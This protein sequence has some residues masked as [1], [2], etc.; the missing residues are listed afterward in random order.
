MAL[1]PGTMRYRIAF[2]ATVITGIAYLGLRCWAVWGRWL[3]FAFSLLFETPL[4]AW[5]I[6]KC[7]QLEMQLHGAILYHVHS[8]K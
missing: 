3:D 2:I 8:F 1:M 5:I 7:H 6:C 4:I